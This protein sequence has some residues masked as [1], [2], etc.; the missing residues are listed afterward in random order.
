[1][2]LCNSS[3]AT[4]LVAN[5]K[6]RAV[7]KTYKTLGIEKEFLSEQEE[8]ILSKKILKPLTH[9]W[10]LFDKMKKI[11]LVSPKGDPNNVASTDWVN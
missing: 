5:K 4:R 6:I 3:Y 9:S 8:C 2:D 10:V 11:V 7:L 1:M